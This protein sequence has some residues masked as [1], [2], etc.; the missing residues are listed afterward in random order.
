MLERYVTMV[1]GDETSESYRR[2]D[3]RRFAIPDDVRL[4]GPGS[5]GRLYGVPGVMREDLTWEIT[6]PE[7]DPTE[8]V[9][10]WAE[11]LHSK[12]DEVLRL[13]RNRA[14]DTPV[15]GA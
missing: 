1:A 11:S 10:G 6:A 13:L 14:R 5:R 7:P 12:L 9:P 8:P 3:G 4:P 2:H 15:N